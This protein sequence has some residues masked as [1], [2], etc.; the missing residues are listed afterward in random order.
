MTHNHLVSVI[1]PAYNVEKYIRQSVDSILNQTYQNIELLIAD[2]K[3]NDNTKD[4]I[5][6]YSDKRIIRLHNDVNLGYL[7]T[8]NKLFEYAKGD[9][10]TFQ[11][12]DD[13]SEPCRIE[14]LVRFIEEHSDLSLVASYS[15]IFESK[16]DKTFL[17]RQ[18]PVRHEEIKKG[19]VLHNQFS[20]ATAFFKSCVLKD[21]GFYNKYFDRIGNED[22]DW[23]CRVGE[24]YKLAVY[25]EVLYHVR[26][27]KSSV[28]KSIKN[29]RQLISRDVVHFLAEQRENKNGKDGTNDIDLY[30]ELKEFEE[31]ILEDYDKDQALMFRKAAE[32]NFYNKLFQ[33]AEQYARR[34]I[35]MNPYG[36]VNWRTWFYILRKANYRLFSN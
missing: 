18:P 35:K 27:N 13:W 22:Y 11:D 12:A 28:T 26:I 34:S 17:V 2:D 3:S 36:L 32:L 29:P 20:G 14:K 23:F 8:C 1:M 9:F 30:P 25:P 6:Q 4:I 7:E 16:S 15:R 33:Q 19:L 24:K 31:K 21:I 5:D 10:I